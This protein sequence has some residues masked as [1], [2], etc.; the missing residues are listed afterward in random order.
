MTVL[1]IGM[2][3]TMAPQLPGAPEWLATHKH[4][5]AT[6]WP[7]RWN[8]FTE[9]P[10]EQQNV[11]YSVSPERMTLQSAITLHMSSANLWGLG[12]SSDAQQVEV[13]YLMRQIPPTRWVSCGARRQYDCIQAVLA[14]AAYTTANR[15]PSPTMCG[16]V[17]LATRAPTG[18]IA[19]GV[20]GSFSCRP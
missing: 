5:Y 3:A 15:F 10:D 19:K 16:S 13:A 11:A 7:Q 4:A 14:Q 8:F 12:R 1:A 9:N 20:L 6:V 18:R 2:V 17:V